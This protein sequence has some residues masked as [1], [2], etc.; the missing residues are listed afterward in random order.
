MAGRRKDRDPGMSRSWRWAGLFVLLA[1]VAGCGITSEPSQA[2]GQPASVSLS[3][4]TV[5]T[6]RSVTVSPAK[7]S[8]GDCQG[9]FASNNTASTPGELGFPNG[10]CWVGSPISPTSFPIKITNTGIASYIYVNGSDA[11]PSDQITQWTL[12]NTGNNPAAACADADGGLPGTNQYLVANFGPDG[13]R[14]FSGLT[15]TPQCD[16]QFGQSGHCWAKQ[17][18]SQT[19][20]ILLVGPA[21]STDTSTKWTVTITWTPVPG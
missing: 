10:R 1:G 21:I 16:R 11:S 20:G 3:L 14:R 8:F 2:P 9:G 4:T 13:T 7:A 12:C 6:I 19:E 18:S 5:P 17:G 15:A